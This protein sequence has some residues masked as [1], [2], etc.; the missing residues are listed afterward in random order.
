MLILSEVQSALAADL[1]EVRPGT[2]SEFSGISNDSRTTRPGELFFALR[3][4]R[5]DGHDFVADAVA[6]GATGV[7][8]EKASSLPEA[9]GIFTVGDT[10]HA[11]GALAAA[12][13]DSFDVKVIAITG[14]VGKTTTKE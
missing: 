1:V 2:S 3:T 4:E 5:R 14:N 12:W 8:V 7:V 11:L 10:T 9:V 13:R 6:H